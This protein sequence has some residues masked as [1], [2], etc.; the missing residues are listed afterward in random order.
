MQISVASLIVFGGHAPEAMSQYSFVR[1]LVASSP[2]LVHACGYSVWSWCAASRTVERRFDFGGIHYDSWYVQ[3][4]VESSRHGCVER[5]VSRRTAKD[6]A[7]VPLQ[8]VADDVRVG[9]IV[10]GCV[11]FAGVVWARRRAAARHVVLL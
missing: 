5:F 3:W 4:R 1:I 9:R 2:A 6:V 7:P 11:A 8:S 10:R